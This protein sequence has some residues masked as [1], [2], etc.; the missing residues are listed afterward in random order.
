[1]NCKISCS[2][3]E[4]VDKVTILK[5]KQSKATDPNALQNIEKELN[6]IQKENPEVNKKDVL[7]EKLSKIN[8]K[9]WL[10]EDSIREKSKKKEF[11]KQYIEYAESI[12]ITNDQRY[13]VKKQINEKYNSNLKEEKVYNTNKIIVNLNDVKNLEI[14]K[15]LYIDGYYT[16]SMSCIETIMKKYENYPTYDSFFID[17]LFSYSNICAIF[18][19]TFPYFNK[20]K[21]IMSIIDELSISKVQKYFCKAIYTTICFEVKKYELSY[22]YIGI[23]NYV[24]GPNISFENMSF[25]KKTDTNKTLLIYEGGGLGDKFMLSRFIPKLCEDYKENKIIFFCYDKLVWFFNNIFKEISNIRIIP[26]SCPHF[27]PEFDYHCSLL[28]LIKHLN[29][30]YNTLYKDT[31]IH[32]I[33]VE[34]TSKCKEIISSFNKPT[35]ILNWKGSPKNPHEKHNRMM[36]LI[37]AIPLFEISNIQWIVITRNITS[38]EKKILKN[39]NV[40]TYGNVID[41]EKSFYDTISI[42]RNVQGVVSVDTSLPHLS[43]SLGIKTFVLLTLGCEWR[44]GDENTTKWYPDAIL[45]KQT[46]LSDWKDPINE[47]KTMLLETV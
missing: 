43:L 37:N 13:L 1:M 35:Y 26:Q 5:I 3:G 2:F 22:K 40:K 9:L 44:W 6:I 24:K 11:D 10:L 31:L 30:T 34:L 47:L 42:L 32:N 36:N 27:L 29:I 39:Y 12:H 41:K 25:F 33:N 45:L 17:L 16:Q 19:K 8:K 7:F 18:D 46:K 15:K 14:A 23:I 20:I 4:I 38:Q 28:S 21:E